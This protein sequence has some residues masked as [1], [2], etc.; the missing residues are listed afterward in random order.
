MYV[1][2]SFYIVAK[3]ALLPQASVLYTRSV[4][5][6]CGAQGAGCDQAQEFRTHAGQLTVHAPQLL[7]A[8][9]CTMGKDCVLVTESARAR[10]YFLN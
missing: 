5:F 7:T 9:S 4:P 6:R 2:L 8:P 10:M 1:L 3:R